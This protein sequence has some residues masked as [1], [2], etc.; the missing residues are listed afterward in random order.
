L[1]VWRAF[2]ARRSA[3][4]LRLLRLPTL[5]SGTAIVTVLGAGLF[6]T[7]FLLPLFLQ[8][9]LG[10]S[11]TESGLVLMPRSLAM[12]VLMPFVGRMYN[13]IGP[14]VLVGLGL[15]LSAYSFFLLGHLTTQ[16]GPWDLLVPQL[17]Q[18]AAFSLIFVALSTAALADV[19]RPDLTAAAG[20]FNVAR[21]VGGSVGVAVSAT[22][23]GTATTRFHSLLAEH[24]TPYDPAARMWL[25]RVTAAMVQRGADAGTASQR[26]L[27]LLDVSATRQAAV[28]AYNRVFIG[29]AFMFLLAAPLVLLLYRGQRT[30]DHS[31]PIE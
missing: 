19:P 13:R 23:V 7:L 26:A 3:V 27:A 12:A 10:Y 2:T 15:A 20:L 1:F 22:V 29:V 17:W 25:S 24:L 18:G 28:L 14:R 6:G 4:D 16:V 31:A 30:L 5:A 8:G 21:Q 11:A 9:L